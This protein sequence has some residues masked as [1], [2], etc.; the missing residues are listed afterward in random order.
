MAGHFGRETDGGC[1]RQWERHGETVTAQAHPLTAPNR[2]NTTGPRSRITVRPVLLTAMLVFVVL[3][4]ACGSG[5][6]APAPGASVTAPDPIRVPY[7][8][9][10]DQYL[11]VY[12]PTGE[13][14]PDAMTVVLIHG[15]FWR[16]QYRSD[17]MVPLAED[18][19]ARGH[20]AVNIEYRRVGGGGGW[21]TTFRD[22]AA[23]IDL[24]ADP[25]MLGQQAMVFIDP[26]RV[27]TVGH[28]AGGHLAVWA[29]S[30]HRI[31]GD[32][33]DK[34]GGPPLVRPC[35]AV[36]QAG[37]VAFGPG[38]SLGDGAVVALMGDSST[39][40]P[41]RYAAADPAALTPIGI[42]VTLV[43][44]RG[45]DIVPLSQSEAYA[46]AADAAGDDAEVVAVD[47]DHFVNL[48]PRSDAWAAVIDA[49]DRG[50]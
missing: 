25:T 38:E 12:P 31:P 47:G 27:V 44:G 33:V 41:E 28:S 1:R 3:L 13:T 50:C 26:R 6:T 15:G 21:P 5:R 24:L 37:V 8:E 18:L 22:V 9:L 30:R 16:E 14:N 20:T 7:G 36:P 19:A 48:D 10:P 45:D 32:I 42:P 17:L 11:D 34:L 46:A 4:T 29:A 49:I 23:A 35:R 40:V 39:E 43:H 2:P